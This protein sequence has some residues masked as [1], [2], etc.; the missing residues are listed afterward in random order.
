MN[1]NNDDKDEDT[2]Y[3]IPR[4]DRRQ[5]I[6]KAG[7]F[8]L[9]SAVLSPEIFT[10]G[11]SFAITGRRTVNIGC[12]GPS[13]CATPIVHA[14]LRNYFDKAGLRVN[15]T[16]YP[17]M[18]LIAK[19]LVSGKLDFGQLIV[20][21]VFAI[22]TGKNPLGLK[23]PM[24]ICQITGTNGAAL[25]VKKGLNIS[26][27]EDFKGKIMANHSKLSV[28][29]LINRMFLE[30]YGLDFQNDV[31]FKVINL[32]D[33]ASAMQRGE[34]DTFVM[35]EPKDA[36]VETEGIGEVYLLSKYIW[37][38]HPCCSLVARKEL[39]E[40]ERELVA[41]VTRAVTQSGLDAN[42]PNMREEVID[43]LQSVPDFKYN[44][45][46]REVLKKAF[47]PGRSDFYPF[48]YQS[49]AMLIIEIMK[50]YGLLDAD[51]EARKTAE[52]VFLSDFSRQVMLDLGAD[53]PDE[54]FRV[55][56]ILGTLKDYS[57][58]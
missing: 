33:A 36:A 16:N 38:N 20:P 34:V 44:R 12:F 48:P 52:E 30:T 51:L 50:K 10:P 37:P 35:P 7:G 17:A 28:H 53:P 57:A 29:Y 54:N 49:T 27:P 3:K 45:I 55:E 9:T 15:V 5:F 13:H 8:V 22:H 1:S 26:S 21:L 11:T 40:N 31:N 14:R 43:I 46:P 23:A 47:T 18:P 32:N 24:V 19:D 42:Q 56:K 41:D 58:L 6:R 2:D 25:M 4:Y 39:Y